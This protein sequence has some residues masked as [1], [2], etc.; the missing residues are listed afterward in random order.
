MP[1][2]PGHY[3]PLDISAPG[4]TSACACACV[5]SA[6]TLPNGSSPGEAMSVKSKKT[7]KKTCMI[8]VGFVIG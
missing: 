4:E 7:K 8:V 3:G 2:C 1:V 6:S 5:L